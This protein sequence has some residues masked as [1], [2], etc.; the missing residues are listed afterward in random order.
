[1]FKKWSEFRRRQRGILRASNAPTPFAQTAEAGPDKGFQADLISD[2]VADE[3]SL[4][5][6]PL[7]RLAR[8]GPGLI[9]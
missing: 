8:D 1:M 7:S 6:M 5:L 2:T 3:C 9:R 4:A